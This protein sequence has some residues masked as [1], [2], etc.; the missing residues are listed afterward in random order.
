MEEEISKRNEGYTFEFKYRDKKTDIH[1]AALLLWG[2]WLISSEAMMNIIINE[3][4]N[5]EK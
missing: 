1:K 3:N 2:N 5:K 4:Q